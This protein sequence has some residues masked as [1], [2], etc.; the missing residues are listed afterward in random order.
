MANKAEEMDFTCARSWRRTR[1][2]DSTSLLCTLHVCMAAKMRVMVSVRTAEASGT[3]ARSESTANR[4][5]GKIELQLQ[6]MMG[7][8]ECAS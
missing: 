7:T 3:E 8:R 1:Q 6:R 5:N 2:E 4:V